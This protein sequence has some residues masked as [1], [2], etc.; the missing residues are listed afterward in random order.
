MLHPDLERLFPGQPALPPLVA[1]PRAVRP[2]VLDGSIRTDLGRQLGR[3]LAERESLGYKRFVVGLSG[4]VDSA[5]CAQ[6]VSDAAPGAVQA[7]VVDLG[8]STEEVHLGAELAATM[9]LPCTVINAADA[10]EAQLRLVPEGSIIGQI[11]LRSRIITSLLF[12]VADVSHGVVVDTTDRSEEILRLY[13]EG[14]RG[15]V[16]PVI[17]LY[18]SELYAMANT[19]GL[20][21]LSESGC[22]DLNNLDAFGLAWQQLDAILDALA[23]RESVPSLMERT[24]LDP[25]WVER[26]ERRIRVQPLRTDIVHLRP[27]SSRQT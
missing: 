21:E 19:M 18:K 15:N 1:Q 2:G 24:G 22:P 8:D 3:Y 11:H 12:Q 16:A 26:L 27:A 4:G 9:Q 10:F 6:L 5:V 20:G 25:V 23:N 7:V 13:E 17:D 14:R